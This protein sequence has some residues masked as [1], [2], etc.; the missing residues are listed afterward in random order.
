MITWRQSTNSFSGYGYV[1]A[2]IF[3]SYFPGPSW[4][5]PKG[6]PVELLFCINGNRI[7]Y[8]QDIE[9]AKAVA[10]E[11]LAGWLKRA[12][13][14]QKVAMNNIKQTMF[15]TGIIIAVAFLVLCVV[16]LTAML[17]IG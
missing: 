10:E 11:F 13:L 17:I 1:G 5:I 2:A 3:F 12:G 7:G 6:K 8:Y 9:V 15:T 16:M 14:K 4:K